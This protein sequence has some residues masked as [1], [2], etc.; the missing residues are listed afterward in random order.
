MA[1]LVGYP[2]GALPSQ[3]IQE[4]LNTLSVLL[5]TQV[6]TG[7]GKIGLHDLLAYANVMAKDVLT[8][9][10][11]V[12]ATL[13]EGQIA[14]NAEDMTLN[15]GLAGGSILQLGEEEVLYAVNQTGNTI[16]NGQ[17][18]VVTG[19]QGNRVVISLAQAAETSVP[20][21]LV[22]VA[23]QAVENNQSGYFT[24]SGL[25][26]DINTSAWAAGTVL[27]VSATAGQLTSAPPS[28]PLSQIPI[29]VVARQHD[30]QGSLLVAPI[31]LPR[32]S[33]LPDVSIT[34]PVTGQALVYDAVTKLWKNANVSGGTATNQYTVYNP[35][36]TDIPRGAAVYIAGG[37]ES[38]GVIYPQ[39]GLA[40]ASSKV[41]ASFTAMSHSVIPAGGFGTILCSGVLDGVDTS[42]FAQ[43]SIVYLSPL[44]AGGLTTIEPGYPYYSCRMAIVTKSAVNGSLLVCPD[45]DPNFSAGTALISGAQTFPIVLTSSGVGIGGTSIAT[46]YYS[47]RLIPAANL[48]V[49]ALSVFVLQSNT[50][51]GMR[52]GVYEPGAASDTLLAQ[53][54]L[55]SGTLALGTFTLPV[56]RDSAGAPLTTTLK[57]KANQSYMLGIQISAN[58]SQLAGFTGV[59]TN[60]PNHFARASWSNTGIPTSGM[61]TSA[62]AS[63][64]NVILWFGL[65]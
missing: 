18:V 4:A 19:S 61:V 6:G 59:G 42:N 37:H 29:G 27:Y 17:P 36:A 23:T 13:S 35:S 47:A 43:N 11:A 60:P 48:E 25:V 31:V 38:G 2:V 54:P 28:K 8:F 40:I 62:S 20:Y 58:G 52:M 3:T 49:I 53:T 50:C 39:V 46:D 9:N 63:Q 1:D 24:R 33:H 65:T 26:R 22:A 57:L 7:N 21:Q 15:V 10:T 32:M 5:T 30:Q 16:A 34:S 45:T 44:T 51:L 14:W 12:G 41:S 56:S 55:W 64:S